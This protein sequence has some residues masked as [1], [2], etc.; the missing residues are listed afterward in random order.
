MSYQKKA[1]FRYPM[2]Y[3][4]ITISELEKVTYKSNDYSTINSQFL[5]KEKP[6]VIMG[7]RAM[8]FG[9]SQDWIDPN[10]PKV[11]ANLKKLAYNRPMFSLDTYGKDID[12]IESEEN[13]ELKRKEDWFYGLVNHLHNLAWE[14][15]K[16]EVGKG[17]KGTK[18]PPACISSYKAADD[19]DAEREDIQKSVFTYPSKKDESG[20]PIKPYIPD[21][22]KTPRIK[23]L[24]KGSGKGADYLPR[25]PITGPK[26]RGEKKPSRINPFEHIWTDDDKKMGT[27]L[28]VLI[29]SVY[30]GQCGT[31]ASYTS[32]TRFTLEEAQY[33]PMKK[34]AM[35]K[36]EYLEENPDYEEDSESEDEEDVS[37]D[38]GG[39][40]FANPEFDKDPVAELTS[41]MEN[42]LEDI[43]DPEPEPEPEPS[44]KME[45]KKSVKSK[46]S[47][48]TKKSSTKT[49]S[50]KKE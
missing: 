3:K 40:D 7:I 30:W 28:D 19:P 2:D 45:K 10:G 6:F 44:P 41:Q 34:R 32:I 16:R 23:V 48:T 20:K 36:L 47:T 12:D 37:D 27:I 22:S 5:Y 31:T 24:L 35:D 29:P 13:K 43:V 17:K 9:F 26:K 14:Q 4:D 49:K 8:I 15:F 50:K 42:E 21:K 11:R 46:K 18:L 33:T 25:T 39:D 38:E 1:I